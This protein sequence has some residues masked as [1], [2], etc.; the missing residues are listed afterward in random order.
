MK[1]VYGLLAVQ[2]SITTL[3]GAVM[4]FTPGVKELVQVGNGH[5]TACLWIVEKAIASWK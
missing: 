2:L 1:K 5:P 4:L 3:I